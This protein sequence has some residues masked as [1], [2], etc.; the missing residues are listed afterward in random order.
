MIPGISRFARTPSRP[1]TRLHARHACFVAALLAAAVP[2]LAQEQHGPHYYQPEVHDPAALDR[3]GSVKVPMDSWIY[4]ALE[5]LST[6]GLIPSQNLDIRP[7]TRTECLRQ[8]NE[9][10]DEMD[11][12][13][14]VQDAP[15]IREASRMIPDLKRELGDSPENDTSALESVYL[16]AGAIAGPAV[17]DG[18]HYGQT[19]WNDFGRP[20][21]R[22]TSS[23][24]GFSARA[25]H[26]RFFLYA[27]EEFQR[28]PGA[29]AVS[30]AQATFFTGVDTGPD[31]VPAGFAFP[32]VPATAAYNRIRPIEL[33]AGGDFAGNEVTFGKQE[34]YWGPTTAGPLAFSSNAEPTY[35][36][37]FDATRQHPIPFLPGLG[38]YRFDLVFGK[39]SGH[40]YPARPYFN[41]QKIS[42]N[43][44]KALEVG[45]TRWS[46]LWGVGHPMTLHTLRQNLFSFN[47]TGNGVYGDRTD[48]GDRKSGFDFRLHVPGL[49]QRLTLYADSYADDEPSPVDAP[50][51]AAWSPGIYLARIPYLPHADLRL[52][53]V[54]T[55]AF[56]RDEG[57]DRFFINNQYLDGNTNKG[58][59]L[60]TAAGRDA[61]IFEVRAGYW[62]SARTRVELGVRQ[63]K[64]GTNFLP[65][66]GTITDGF[67]QAYWAFRPEWTVNAF[68]Q[69]ERF[70]IPAMTAGGHH[71]TSARLQLTWTPRVTAKD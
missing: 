51:R 39:L 47:S 57:G 13:D 67:V 60:G 2:G 6:M 50:R 49:G 24:A 68:A 44:G 53:V 43:L 19:W 63:N 9:A 58:F 15:L 12:L 21:G 17:I 35:N 55:E 20:L 5:R 33:Y 25:T 26:G 32:S 37:R 56:A 31:A 7:W 40:H 10:Q 52:E 66:G 1:D 69:E 16:R 59:L 38:T 62:F 29:V 54:S 3:I 18:F 28:S 41:G 46:I 64:G 48:P 45:F 65:G 11:V 42:L 70:L 8:L 27:R 14:R 23:I 61:R 4:P 34:L 30:P 71:N 22:G 36:L